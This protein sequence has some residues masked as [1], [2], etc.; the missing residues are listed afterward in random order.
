MTAPE[1]QEA[2]T[3]AV[4]AR[5]VCIAGA[6][7]AR[8]YARAFHE[9]TASE[10]AGVCTRTADSAARV[11]TE[12]GGLSYTDFEAM[13]ATE[14]P[15]VV[16][17]ATPNRLHH[18][19]TM[20]ALDAGAEVI[21]EKPLALDGT[22]A[23]EMAARAATLGRRAA[24]SFTW[25][26]LP[27]CASL[28]SLLAE[29]R[30]GAIYQ[31]DVRYHT[32][33]FGAVHGPMRWQYRRSDAGSGALANLGSHAIDLVH[34]WFGPV[35]RVTALTRTVIGERSGPEGAEPVSV[36]DVA[37]AVLRLGDGV[38]VSLSVGWVSHLTRVGLEVDVHGSEGS[39]WLRYATD[40]QPT[41]T[42]ELAGEADARPVAVELHAAARAWSDLGQ[43]CVD[44]LVAAFLADGTVPGFDDGLRA[45]C[46]LDAILEAA[47]SARW[48]DVSYPEEA[49]WAA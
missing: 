10:I 45:Q 25:R 21:C 41:G 27:A 42:L 40:G 9:A 20:R 8:R 22:Q 37:A 34:W 44:G 1:L 48:V 17:V 3:G 49:G 13:L 32:R 31:V 46:V 11:V 47:T 14:K 43:A 35:E 29:K 4:G 16:V 19:M 28:R 7:F 30:L 36:E 33:G 38:P 24:T 12:T 15:D 6:G 26:F 23:R 2:P 18:P 5:R 39:A